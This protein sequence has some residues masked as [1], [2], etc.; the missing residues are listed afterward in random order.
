MYSKNL[1]TPGVF[2]GFLVIGLDAGWLSKFG[3]KLSFSVHIDK[4]GRLHLVSRQCL[5]QRG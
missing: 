1:V 5:K 4:S 3:G 2:E